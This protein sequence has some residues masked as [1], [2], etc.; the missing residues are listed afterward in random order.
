MA[1]SETKPLL[2]TRLPV[3][4][5][6]EL[7]QHGRGFRVLRVY[8]EANRRVDAN[9]VYD[10]GDGTSREIGVPLAQ[11]KKAYH[12]HSQAP[13]TL[14]IMPYEYH[15]VAP[16]I[17]MLVVWRV[18]DTTDGAMRVKVGRGRTLCGDY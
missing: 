12:N 18:D 10:D 11:L 16:S 7:E 15:L 3:T 6:Y 1:T 4:A 8:E 2:L 5:V 9:R 13:H 14:C 17:P